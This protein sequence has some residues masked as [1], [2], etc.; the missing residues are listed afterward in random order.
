MKKI[1][2]LL[3]VLCTM[4]TC[5]IGCESQEDY[6][7]RV[8]KAVENKVNGLMI[9]N[10]E[11]SQITNKEWSYSKSE[12]GQEVVTMT[13][14][15]TYII[16]ATVVFR[17][18]VDTDEGYITKMSYTIGDHSETSDIAKSDRSKLDL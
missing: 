3:L 2:C 4:I 15:I 11:F 1:L 14:T 9:E 6:E 18:Y 13:G 12:D 7:T 8:I 17:F 5:A 10:E 16:S